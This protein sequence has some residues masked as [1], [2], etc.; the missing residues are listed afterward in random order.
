MLQKCKKLIGLNIGM[1]NISYVGWECVHV[2]HV[3]LPTHVWILEFNSTNH[4]F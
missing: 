4:D 2:G 1:E 3:Y